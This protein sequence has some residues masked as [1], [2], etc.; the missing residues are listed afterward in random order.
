M[1][2]TL[3]LFAALGK[4][5]P[6]EAHK[7]QTEMEVPDGATPLD[8]MGL[9]GVPPEMAHLVLINGAFVAPP[10]RG[11]KQLAEGDSLAMWPPVAGG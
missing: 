8:V 3:K 1:R 10:Q 11:D 6:P 4:Y 5:L 9:V 2:I 7:N